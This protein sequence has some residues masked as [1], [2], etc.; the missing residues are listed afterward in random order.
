[1]Q[2]RLFGLFLV[3]FAAM[4]ALA[5]AFSA[6]AGADY[7]VLHGTEGKVFVSATNDA[8]VEG[9]ISF[10]TDSDQIS[11]YAE[12]QAVQRA[13][14]GE[15][16]GTYVLISAPDCF[17]GTAD[18]TVTVQLAV[19]QKITYASTTI[20]AVAYPTEQCD[21]YQEGAPATDNYV[22]AGSG[23]TALFTAYADPTEYRVSI[24]GGEKAETMGAGQFKRMKLK[25]MNY[26]AAGTFELRAIGGEVNAALTKESVSLQRSEAT[27]VYLDVKPA[28]G[29]ADGRY[30]TTVQVMAQ[31]Q[32]IY[33]RDIA[34]DVAEK[35]DVS[36][37][38]PDAVTINGSTPV[39]IAAAVKNAGTAVETLKITV[40]AF[41]QAP[42][43]ISV[44]AGETK[45]FAIV[46]DPAKLA[47]GENTL[48]VRVESDAIEGSGQV[49]VTAQGGAQELKPIPITVAVK[50]DGNSSLENVTGS[51][52]GI[53]ASWLVMKGDPITV[54]AHGEA[55]MT[56]YIKPTTNEDANPILTVKS[57]DTI[58][59]TIRLPTIKA[60]PTGIS[61]YFT[62]LGGNTTFIG[63][64]VAVAVVVALM[65]SRARMD[66]E[67]AARVKKLHAVREEVKA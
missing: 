21:R 44:K 9:T 11:A 45:T 59:Q 53:P 1:M 61:G 12:N 28:Q 25:L 38:L 54:P 67:Y 40:S 48:D 24:I 20:R 34:V 49:K 8:G 66:D 56:L 51:I 2:V 65:M 41:A 52:T 23:K 26:G 33:E 18:V 7:V 46:V 36:L 22:A 42:A 14:A 57:G 58:L 55:N 50:N 60:A 29:T 62:A 64:L 6:Q 3:A 16:K 15:T 43:A 19:D 30:F 32:I 10:S 31:G 63:V 17:R 35:H 5:S 27:D 47:A 13:A 37:A 4:G 39:A